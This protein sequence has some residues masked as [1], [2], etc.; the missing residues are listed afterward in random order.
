MR[1]Q[2]AKHNNE[3]DLLEEIYNI[4]PLLFLLSKTRTVH[5]SPPPC[6]CVSSTFTF[7]NCMPSEATR[8]Q[9]QEVDRD[10]HGAREGQLARQGKRCG[11]RQSNKTSVTS[12]G[13]SRGGNQGAVFACI[14]SS[15]CCCLICCCAAYLFMAIQRTV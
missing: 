12:G 3:K 5:A 8:E 2:K 1:L 9:Q 13:F 6:H 10:Y 4:F 7:T 14:V 15:V 11:A